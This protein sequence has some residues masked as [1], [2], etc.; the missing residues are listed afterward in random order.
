MGSRWLLTSLNHRKFTH[1]SVPYVLN[2]CGVSY[3]SDI[4]G[5]INMRYPGH[6]GTSMK[7]HLQPPPSKDPT[8]SLTG[9]FFTF[10]YGSHD[11]IGVTQPALPFSRSWGVRLSRRCPLP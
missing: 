9:Q 5:P 10:R 8:D 11:E 3:T 6:Q 4:C 7:G 1:I 2:G